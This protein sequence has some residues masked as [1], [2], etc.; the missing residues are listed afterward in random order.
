MSLAHVIHPAFPVARVAPHWTSLLILD[1][2]I[3]V[4]EECIGALRSSRRIHEMRRC[5]SVLTDVRFE[6][7]ML[8]SAIIAVEQASN[9]GLSAARA[10]AAAVFS[11]CT[12][13]AG[14][15]RDMA[16]ADESRWVSVRERA[17]QD[18]SARV[19]NAILPLFAELEAPMRSAALRLQGDVVILNW[20]L[21]G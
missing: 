10:Y 15:L 14:S 16:S 5:L 2:R 20:N 11:W 19:R 4:A 12:D 17:A 13:V 7:E 9:A 8:L 18:S 3:A 21:R 1:A 6:L